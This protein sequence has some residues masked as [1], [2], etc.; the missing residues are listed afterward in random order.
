M[1]VDIYYLFYVFRLLEPNGIYRIRSETPWL[2]FKGKGHEVEDLKKMMI[3]YKVWANQLYP[4]LNFT[5]FADRVMKVTSKKQCKIVLDQWRDEYK[6][7]NSLNIEKD[8]EEHVTGELS[9]M[10]LEDEENINRANKSNHSSDEEDDDDKMDELEYFSKLIQKATPAESSST[11]PPSIQ[12]QDQQQKDTN[13]QSAMDDSDD[14]VFIPSDKIK[15]IQEKQPA[16]SILDENRNENIKS[17]SQKNKNSSQSKIILDDSDSDSDSDDALLFFATGQS[18]KSVLKKDNNVNSSQK[19]NNSSQTE[20]VLNDSGDDK[21][22]RTISQQK[23]IKKILEDSDGDGD[24]IPSLQN[25]P[26]SSS[27]RYN[28]I[29]DDDEYNDIEEHISNQTKQDTKEGEQKDNQSVPTENKNKN[30]KD[31]E[32]PLFSKNLTSRQSQPLSVDDFFAD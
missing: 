27:I 24:V 20:K 21:A 17:P 4:R 29:I 22:M 10:T 3:Y 26:N 14:E 16:K 9:G 18:S 1:E 15:S 23:Q 25:K 32:E 30:D 12:T 28:T 7:K 8:S 5:D 11:S 2:K 31:D 13:K 6:F 19:N